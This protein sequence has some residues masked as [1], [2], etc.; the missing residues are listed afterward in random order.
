MN[1]PHQISTLPG[2]WNLYIITDQHL[3]R[4]RSH[5]EI[6][7][8]ALEGGADV[9]Q[10]R[11]KSASGYEL[12]RTGQELKALINSSQASYI[13]NDRIDIAMATGADGVH[14][15]Q[16]DLPAV[17][18]RRLISPGK[19]LGVSASSLEEALRARDDG[20]DYLGV[21]PV[22][23]ARGTK[24]DSGEPHGL[25]LVSRIR[26]NCDLPI[27]AI[28]GINETN[29][30]EVIRAGAD[31]AAVISAVVSSENITKT[32]AKLRQI[33]LSAKGIS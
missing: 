2:T 23:E 13:V 9:I 16:K 7:R 29:L 28:G 1:K 11:D 18:A 21:G 31:A 3:S 27:V 19:I 15:G 6:A 12:Y 17:V 8:E 20:A 26:E 5:L 10:L 25:S 4:G 32:V 30:S 24:S 14:V 33:I 22:F